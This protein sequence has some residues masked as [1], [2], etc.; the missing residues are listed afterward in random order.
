MRNEIIENATSVYTSYK[1]LPNNLINAEISGIYG[2]ALL[3]EM[4]ELIELYKIYESGADFAVDTSKDY[5]PSD[6]KIK[7][8]KHLIDKEARFMFSIPLDINIRP[9]GKTLQNIEK[10]CWSMDWILGLR[11]I[12]NAFQMVAIFQLI[13]WRLKKIISICLLVIHLQFLFHQLLEN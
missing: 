13:L 3:S 8:S 12:L 7:K 9:K 5:T 11:V 4:N 2:S 1:S 6:L 10:I